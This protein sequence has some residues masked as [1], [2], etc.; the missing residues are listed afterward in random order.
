MTKNI[1]DLDRA[2]GRTLR[3]AR[4]EAG[5]SMGA[6]A[7]ACEISF[8]QIQKYER[9][10]NRITASRLVTLA[11]ALGTTAAALLSRAETAG[12]PDV[13]P[14]RRALLEL[15]RA[16]APLDTGIVTA[17]TAVA[18]EIQRAGGAPG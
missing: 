9:G 2:I 14:R 5:M 8:Q 4:L 17:L 18:R 12:G 15:T 13:P 11:A 1:N 10:A 16:A 6:L 7:T 3:D